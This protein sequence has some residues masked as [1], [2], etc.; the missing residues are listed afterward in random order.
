MTPNATNDCSYVDR[1]GHTKMAKFSDYRHHC[2]PEYQRWHRKYPRFPGI[3]ECARLIQAGKAPR[4][5]AD[6]IAYELAENAN[7]CLPLLIDAF[8]NDSS[9]D[10]EIAGLQESVPFL[11]EVLRGGDPRFIPYAERTPHGINTQVARTA[12]WQ[13]GHS[14]PDTSPDNHV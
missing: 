3:D 12:L 14:E 5:W 6:I 2:D 4:A 7:N 1:V 13:A 11:V 9:D 8:R 10:V